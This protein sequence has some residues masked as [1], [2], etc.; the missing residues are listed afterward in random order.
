MF[1][2]RIKYVLS[3]I[4]KKILAILSYPQYLFFKIFLSSKFTNKRF[5]NTIFFIDSFRSF[6]RIKY[7]HKKEIKTQKWIKS[8]K[9]E[10]IFWDIGSNVGIFSFLAIER[11]SKVVSFEPLFSNYNNLMHTLHLNKN[12]HIN[13]LVLPLFLNNENKHSMQFIPNIESGYSGIQFDLKKN[14]LDKTNIDKLHSIGFSGDFLSKLLNKKFSIPNYIKIDVDGNELKILYGLREVLSNKKCISLLVEAK[15]IKEF[16]LIKTYIENFGFVLTE[17][18]LSI[19]GKES[20]PK[21]LI[22]HKK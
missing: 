4:K 16:K 18:F 5:N 19:D 17:K 10:S 12:Y 1:K 14:Y 2:K 21:N 9:K 7:A 15:S 3:E 6:L 8:F 11:S 20:S 22:F 13:L